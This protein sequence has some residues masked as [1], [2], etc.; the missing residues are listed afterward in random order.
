MTRSALMR[1]LD[2]SAREPWA[3]T[4]SRRTSAFRS[5]ASSNRGSDG[6]AGPKGCI[7]TW[8]PRRSSSTSAPRRRPDPA[9]RARPMTT[10]DSGVYYDPYDFEIDTNPYP[11]WRA[12][13]RRTAPLLQ[14][15]LRL[16]CAQP[17]RGRRA[18]LGRLEDVQLGTG[19]R[20]RADQ[21]R[22]GDAARHDDL[23]GSPG[24]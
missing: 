13:P 8:K 1:S 7:P 15:A 24:A 16:L 17:V 18:L 19:H 22:R 23:R 9:R 2:E 5:A 4:P 10:T 3:T 14:R 11:V 20:P 12:P 6:K 21:E